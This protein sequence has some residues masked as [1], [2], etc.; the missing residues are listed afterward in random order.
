M[1]KTLLILMLFTSISP[2]TAQLKGA[3][4]DEEI[5]PQKQHQAK[6]VDES[7]FADP[8]KPRRASAQDSEVHLQTSQTNSSQQQPL[9]TR[10]YY[11]PAPPQ[12]LIR[13]APV[14]SGV[15]RLPLNHVPY[16]ID[17]CTPVRADVMAASLAIGLIG[18][19]ASHHHHHKHNADT[20]SINVNVRESQ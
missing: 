11:Q 5:S 1:Y 2:A 20:D 4:N 16:A 6:L 7:Q 3:V 18:A 9:S 12:P 8:P 15:Y 14:I 10:V 19:M 13:Y 17:T